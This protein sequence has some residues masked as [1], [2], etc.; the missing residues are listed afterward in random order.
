MISIEDVLAKD[1]AHRESVRVDEWG[2]DVTIIS[3]TAQERADIEKKYSGGKAIND[4]AGFRLDI[5]SRSIKKDDGSP[6][7][8]PEQFKA[9]LGKNSSAVEKL[10][11]AACEVSGFTKKDV[12]ALEKN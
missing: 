11:E 12:K 3:M 5:L 2:V 7:G 8:T 9:L 10:F 4:P 6:W 1:D